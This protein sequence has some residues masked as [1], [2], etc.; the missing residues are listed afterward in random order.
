MDK[1]TLKPKI[2]NDKWGK[3]TQVIKS[4]QK[5]FNGFTEAKTTSIHTQIVGLPSQPQ[6]ITK[7][8]GFAIQT[9]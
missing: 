5:M 9:D 3:M 6:N 4:F 1:N 7:R 8:D 2:E